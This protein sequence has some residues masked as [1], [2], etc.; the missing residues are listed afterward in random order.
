V[1]PIYRT[2]TRYIIRRWTDGHEVRQITA[3]ERATD[4]HMPIQY[5]FL[6]AAIIT[7]VAATS[8]LPASQQFTRLWPSVIVVVGYGLSFFFLSMT[9]KFM[10]VGVVYAMWSGLGIIA[11]AAIG[12]FA[13]QQRLDLPA[14]LGMGLIISGVI[15]INLFSNSASH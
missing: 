14:M 6:I 1:H 15:V 10:T 9:L 2:L 8:A 12:Y 5:L 13:Y 4:T 7:E 3:T 11:V